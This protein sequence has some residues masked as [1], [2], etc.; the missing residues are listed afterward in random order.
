MVTN[1]YDLLIF[2]NPSSIFGNSDGEIGSTAI[3]STDCVMCLIGL[4][5]CS[6]SSI[7]RATIVAV[8]EMEASTPPSNT[9]LPA[10]ARSVSTTY[11]QNPLLSKNFVRLGRD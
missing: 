5:I 1:G 3:L 6:S 2:R 7:S 9:K 4:K 10:D 8:F 11:L